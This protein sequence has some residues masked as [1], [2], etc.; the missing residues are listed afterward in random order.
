M[1]FKGLKKRN[2]LTVLL[3]LGS[4]SLAAVTVSYGAR[5]VVTPLISPAPQYSTARSINSKG[6][7]TGWAT[8]DIARAF[9]YRN[10]STITLAAPDGVSSTSGLAI[11]ESGQVAGI[12]PISGNQHAILWTNGVPKDL[13]VLNGA[14]GSYP[15]AINDLGA[16]V[17]YSG[18]NLGSYP[19]IWQNGVMSQ[20][21][22][23]IMDPFSINSVGDVVGWSSERPVL[24]DSSG[25]MTH[26]SAANGYAYDINDAKQVVGR[27]A[28]GGTV[29]GFLWQKGVLET[30]PLP[31]GSSIAFPNSINSSGVM[32][33]AG[34]FQDLDRAVLWDNSLVYDLNTLIPA[35]TGW[36][37]TRAWDINDSGQIVG[38]GT[39]N[40]KTQGLIM[41]PVWGDSVSKATVNGTPG[42]SGWYTM[43]VS[44]TLAATGSNVREIHYSLDGAA[45]VVIGDVKAVVQ[46]AGD[47]VHTIRYF[48]AD[49]AGNVEVPNNLTVNIDG[50]L[51]KS[52]VSV[53]GT[54]SAS[55]WYNSPVTVQ[56]SGADATSGVGSIRYRKS[57]NGG[58]GAAIS[59]GNPS[60]VSFGNFSSGGDGR[61]ALGFSAV[62]RACNAGIETVVN[63]NI[64][65]I[66]PATTYKLSTIPNVNGW[67]AGDVTTTFT[68]TDNLSGVAVISVNDANF[69]GAIA[70]YLL[71]TEGLH[72]LNYYAMDFADVKE[73]SRSVIVGIDK[74]APVVAVST[75]PATLAASKKSKLVPVTINGA[76]SDLLSGIA[77]LQITVTDEYG[78]YSTMV[79]SFGTTVYLDTHLIRKDRDGRLYTVKATATDLAGNQQTSVY[80]L[81]VK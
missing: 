67:Y 57:T 8:T 17:G 4:V 13:G 44:V 79:P 52:T 36:V 53:P 37:L 32:V 75:S 20:L 74:T 58:W 6:S 42:C 9:V 10:H 12:A 56:V 50:T 51:P 47:A 28:S 76:A 22:S 69:P 61:Y 43:P 66:P 3:F 30:L 26:L 34:A 18:G 60:S 54:A 45:D 31:V 11:N 2:L 72:T 40:G 16:V 24:R 1:Q 49:Y 73:T 15:R 46:V 63:V 38:E 64:D 7:V 78:T 65:S 23:A 5:Y 14:I 81:L 48:A 39:Y 21:G 35:G 80:D 41:N 27:H 19:F 71:S 70:S 33:G 25:N 55:G 77:S 29:K 68:A 59:G 62:D